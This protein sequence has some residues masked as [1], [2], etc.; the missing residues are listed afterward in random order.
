MKTN[1]IGADADC[2]M[3]E[4]AVERNDF[5][6]VMYS[7]TASACGNVACHSLAFS[8]LFQASWKSQ[9]WM[10]YCGLPDHRL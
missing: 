1:H 4:L 7:S 10:R 5:I 9:R 8:G 2:R 6:G 3:T